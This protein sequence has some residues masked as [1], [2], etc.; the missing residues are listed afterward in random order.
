M[1][2]ETMMDY[3]LV[4]LYNKYADND[5]VGLIGSA[6]ELKKWFE[7]QM[8]ELERHEKDGWD[9]KN[10]GHYTRKWLRRKIPVED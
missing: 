10:E 1:T 3:M 4:T 2:E 7:E 6:G 5:E 8:Q 9:E